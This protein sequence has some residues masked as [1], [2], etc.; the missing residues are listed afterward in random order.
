MAGDESGRGRLGRLFA[1]L[2]SAGDEPLP[3]VAGGA[4]GADGNT[5]VLDVEGLSSSLVSSPDPLA[6]LASLVVDVRGRVESAGLPGEGAALPPSALEVHLASRLVEAGLLE[7][8]VDLPSVHVVRPRTSGLFYLRLDD[9]QVS[10]LALVRV[11]RIEAALNA[12]LLVSHVLPSP[13]DATLEEIV[14]AEQRVARSV[15][16]QVPEVAA[17]AQG[18][19]RGEWEVRRAISYG[20]EALRL[21]YR[22]TARFRVNA[23]DGRAGVELDLVPPAAWVATSYVDGLG[24]VPATRE[25]R[26]RAATD[27]NC[28]LAVL[29]AAYALEVAPQLREVWVAGVVDSASGHACYYSGTLTRDT[30]EGVDLGGSFDA[31]ALLRGAGFAMD[32]LGRTLATVRQTFSLDDARLC[33]PGRYDAPEL[34]DRAL[35]GDQA[36]AL[37]CELVSGLAAD[38]A[39]RRR[40][41]AAE[42][43]RHLSSS[44]EKN[45]RQLLGAARADG[46]EDV[47]EAAR[48]CV[49]GLLDG[50]LPDDP[51][52][53]EE[54]FV[55][56]SDLARA[57]SRARDALLARDLEAAGRSVD[58]ALL[59]VDGLGTY[60]DAGSGDEGDTVWRSFGSY[61]ERALYNRLLARAGEDCRLVPDAYLEAHMIA[62]AAA[63]ARGSVDDALAH[64]RRAAEVAP[65]SAQASANLAQCLEAAG[66][67]DGAEAELC[68]LLSLAHDPES[69]GAGYLGMAQLQ[70]QRG[71]VLAAQAC[72][73]RAARHLGAH[74]LAAGIAVVALIGQVGTSAGGGL[75]LDQADAVLRAAGIPLAPTQEVSEALLGA[76]RAAL[77]AEVFPAA[78]DL[79]RALCSLFRDDVTYGMLRS[80]EDEPDR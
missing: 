28:R 76:A 53:V 15:T 37:G 4:P 54:A 10:Y 1:A 30:L 57:C 55:D 67:E 47:L 56:G 50:T 41:V 71:H 6:L 46:H 74:A 49:A 2:V 38:E 59:P 16:A 24:V 63:V 70:W 43:S 45:V 69:L 40:R 9:R 39:A 73:Q 18:P 52:A 5:S 11:I 79:L 14:R 13:N 60:G 12:A 17:G 19:A 36:A 23:R 21:P 42:L 26:R 22:L 44:T 32:E 25:M 33:P 64:A 75:A 34:S 51:L 35:T 77:D 61:T 62:S 29:V 8:D 66:D 80:L 78:R 72:Y 7:T 27:Y 68:R 31:L 3:D 48:R 65:L 58:E 20:I